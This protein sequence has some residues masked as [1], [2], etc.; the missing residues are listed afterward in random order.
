MY[1]TKVDSF[2][3]ALEVL[4]RF[5]LNLPA[6][7]PLKTRR[8]PHSEVDDSPNKGS[9]VWEAVWADQYRGVILNR[10]KI[11]KLDRVP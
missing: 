1:I 9:Q 2:A 7:F 10:D 6:T 8:F 3:G 4:L 5:G 11:F